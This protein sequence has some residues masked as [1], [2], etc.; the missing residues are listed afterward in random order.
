MSRSVVISK[1]DIRVAT[2][3]DAESISDL[4]S[5]LSR[6]HIAH[7]FTAEGETALMASMSPAAIDKYIDTG[8]QYHIAEMDGRIVGVVAVRD[9]SHIYHLFVA[10]DY[11]RQGIA[12]KLWQEAKDLC[13]SNGNPGQFSVSSSKYAVPVYRKLGFRVESEPQERDG[14]IFVPM[15]LKV[16]G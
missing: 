7:E 3:D 15:K 2:S 1:L 13:F 16:Q 10:E 12:S 8:Y 5:E 11:Q 6:K 4:I 9:N 14:V